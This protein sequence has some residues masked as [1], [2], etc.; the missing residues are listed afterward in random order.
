[1]LLSRWYG[2]SVS[3]QRVPDKVC[4]AELLN[5]VTQKWDLEKDK[6]ICHEGEQDQSL[7]KAEI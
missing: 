3:N 4:P 1:M 7:H 5:K 6:E 2:Y